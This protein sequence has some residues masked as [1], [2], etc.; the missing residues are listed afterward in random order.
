M[1]S[2]KDVHAKSPL[3]EHEGLDFNRLLL[4]HQRDINL[5]SKLPALNISERYKRSQSG[6]AKSATNLRSLRRRDSNSIE[7]AV[8]WSAEQ[9]KDGNN[10][11]LNVVVEA[12]NS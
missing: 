4:N 5:T 10:E 12:C 11:S 9:E 8:R 3:R 7:A 1:F 2:Q 6:G